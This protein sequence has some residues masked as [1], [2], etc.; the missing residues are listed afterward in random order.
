[1][2]VIHSKVSFYVLRMDAGCTSI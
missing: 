1:M 2:Y